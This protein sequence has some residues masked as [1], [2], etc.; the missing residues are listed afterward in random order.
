MSRIEK[1]RLYKQT[2]GLLDRAN[3]LLDNIYKECS[4]KIKK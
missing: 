2:N 3:K 4:E 1:R